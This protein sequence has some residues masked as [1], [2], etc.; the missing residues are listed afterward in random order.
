M[1]GNPGVDV[2][3]TTDAS[4]VTFDRS[5]PVVTAANIDITSTP[6]G[7]GSYYIIGDTITVE[8]DSSATGDNN[9]DVQSAS[10][11]FSEFQG[12]AAVAMTESSRIWTARAPWAGSS[13]GSGRPLPTP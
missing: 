1:P 5:A 4:E 6:S 11:N 2:S 8:W 3:A 7:A 12:G 9:G 10:V 13:P